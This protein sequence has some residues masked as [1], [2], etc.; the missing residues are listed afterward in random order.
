MDFNTIP[1]NIRTPGH[2]AE[3]DATR[4]RKGLPIKTPRV[5][6]IGNMLPAG[7]AAA[8]T[9][10]RQFSADQARTDFG[11]GSILAEMAASFMAS[12]TSAD[13][14]AIG[15]ADAGGGVAATKVVTITGPATAA[16]SLALRVAG[17][18]VAVAVAVGHTATQIATAAAAAIQAHADMPVS[19]ANVAGVLTLTAKNKGTPGNDVDVRVNY[20]R[21]EATPAGVGVAIAAGVT[22]ATDPDAATAIAAMGDQPFDFVVIP[23]TNAAN[24]TA[25][26]TELTR[27]WGP[28]L[29]LDGIAFAA[30]RGSQGA[31]ATLGGTRN[32]PYLSIIGIDAGLNSTWEWAAS[33]AG[34]V[35]HYG[36]LDPARP[37]QTLQ[38]PGILPP[39]AGDEFTRAER[40]L[41]LRD[42]ITTF[43]VDAGGRVLLD[44]VITTYQVDAFGSPDTAYLDV[45]TPLTLSYLRW[46]YVSTM[47][48]AFPRH[49]LADDGTP[50]AAGDAIVTPKVAR[51]KTVA[52]AQ[53]MGKAGLIENVPAFIASLIIERDASNPQRLNTRQAPDLVNQALIFATQ[54]QFVL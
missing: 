17:R 53:D 49:K 26:E 38:L 19:A 45:N 11:A 46:S 32:S 36:G 37:F 8:A 39:A 41:L 10:R 34:L 2:Y 9:L 35:A 23:W 50:A 5:L 30:A 16:G 40:E 12:N 54:I 1:A 25:L 31:L 15:L 24:L 44:R 14:Y 13:V 21:E 33:V 7:T 48:A 29:K 18:S 42:G 22:G 3:I 27:R 51:A 6:L 20:Y 52:W 4:A 28:E 43:K 47:E